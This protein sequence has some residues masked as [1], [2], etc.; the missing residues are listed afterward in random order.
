M[1]IA[2]LPLAKHNWNSE[3]ISAA[4][5]IYQHTNNNHHVKNIKERLE[6]HITFIVYFLLQESFFH[7]YFML[8]ENYY[9]N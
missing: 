9:I 4:V 7:N 2:Y 8:I 5:C 1:C 6:K 3:S